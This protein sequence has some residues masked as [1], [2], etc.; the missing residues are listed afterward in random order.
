[1][2]CGN[3]TA[4]IVRRNYTGTHGVQQLREVV[5]TGFYSYAAKRLALLTVKIL[6]SKH[7]TQKLHR[8]D[9]YKS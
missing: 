2:A 3:Y 6:V 7:R 8:E 4:D 1:M 9:L 5:Y